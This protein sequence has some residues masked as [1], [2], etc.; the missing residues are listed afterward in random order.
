[1]SSEQWWTE[2]EQW[3]MREHNEYPLHHEWKVKPP[4][5]DP[6]AASSESSIQLLSC[7][8]T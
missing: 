5:V 4:S 1:M 6:E 2:N 7:G 3:E 8:T